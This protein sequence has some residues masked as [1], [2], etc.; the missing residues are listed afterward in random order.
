MKVWNDLA[1]LEDQSDIATDSYKLAEPQPFGPHIM[2]FDE[3]KE[4]R[5]DMDNNVISDA[6]YDE[7]DDEAK[8]L[9]NKTFDFARSGNMVQTEEVKSAN[10]YIKIM[11]KYI[12]HLLDNVFKEVGPQKKAFKE[13]ATALFAPGGF[14][15]HVKDN[16]SNFQFYHVDEKFGALNGEGMLVPMEWVDGSKPVFHVYL[17]GTKENK[18]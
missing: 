4:V 1:D 8:S 13:A 18:H 9:C 15:A 5:T 12:K 2:T 16:F 6:E 14:V 10:V 17:F 7:L 3:I 11:K